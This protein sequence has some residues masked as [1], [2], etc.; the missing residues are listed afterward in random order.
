MNINM[1]G[2]GP[3]SLNSRPGLPTNQFKSY[4]FEP[5]LLPHSGGLT[6]PYILILIECVTHP[7][8]S[9]SRYGSRVRSRM[10]HLRLRSIFTER[11][12]ELRFGH[13]LQQKLA[14]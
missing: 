9:V 13:Y 2:C 7:M 3:M 10:I 11:G 5:P 8:L 4:L 14:N 1:Y 12:T 6:N